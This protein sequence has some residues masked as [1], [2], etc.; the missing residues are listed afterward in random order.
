MTIPASFQVKFNN[1]VKLALQA[2]DQ[3]IMGAV[4]HQ[5]DTGAEKVKVQDIVGHGDAVENTERNGATQW[6]DTEFDGV[7]IP[8]PNELYDARLYDSQ[9]QLATAINLQGSGTMSAAASIRRART[10]R[11]LEGFYGDIISGKQGTTVTPFPSGNII[12]V[13]EGGAAGAQK[14]NTKKLRLANVMLTENYA[15][16]GDDDE[17]QRY[18]VLTAEDNDALLTEVP[19]TS[20]DFKA[21][22]Q[23]VFNNGKIM[24]ML[25]WTFIH[26]E[27]DNPRLVTI[28]DLATDGSGYR[29]TPFWVKPGLRVNTWQN[30][31]SE[32]GK[33]P[34]RTFSLGTL[35][36]TTL[37]G[38]RTEAGQ[39]GQI[40]NLKG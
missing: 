4:T 40:L 9:D 32:A 13:T 30:L 24:S 29:R 27:L 18:M 8:K 38:T 17:V 16:D 39:S 2:S 21:A 20:G 26:I 1:N 14:M 10:R 5:S 6:N 19:A 3:R 33:I 22:Y 36:G 31:R 7:W 37:A 23:G 34:E 25:G 11:I 12:A 15:I 35:A 28:P